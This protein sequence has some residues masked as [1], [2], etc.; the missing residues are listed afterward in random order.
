[1]TKNVMNGP[2]AIIKAYVDCGIPVSSHIHVS[3]LTRG[4]KSYI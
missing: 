3:P 2:S 4:W 1:M